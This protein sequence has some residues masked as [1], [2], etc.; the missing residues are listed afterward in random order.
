MSQNR[1][2]VATLVLLALLGVTMWRMSSREAEDR[3]PPKVEVKLPK[4]DSATV[5]ELEL[6]APDK[7]GVRLVK[8]DDKWR[9]AEPLD[10]AADPDTVKTALDKLRELEVTGVAATKAESHEKLEVDPKKAT[11]VIARAGGKTLLDAYVGTYLSGNTM[12]RLEGQTNVATVKGS[13][14]YVFTKQV[15]EW[16]DR[17]IHK[18]DAKDVQQ[19]EFSNK[20]GH[21]AF[22]R[23]GDKWKQVLAKGD[24]KIDPLDDSKL[25]GI[26]STAVNLNATDFADAAITPEQAGLGPSAA[27]V[28]LKLGGD[29]GPQE[30]VYR[31][32]S[33]KDQDYYFQLEGVDTI[34]VMSSWVGGRL[35][36]STDTLVKKP[37]P[38]NNAPPGSPQNPIKV[39]PIGSRMVP[40][41]AGDVHAMGKPIVAIKPNPA[42]PKPAAPAPKK[43]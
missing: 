21:F 38:A 39:D 41:P 32:G 34:F 4:I 26:L 19:V 8:K 14:R 28:R 27:S 7:P 25:T 3:T 15:R 9:L 23:E 29:A 22:V 12:L 35:L 37:E 6:H 2:G 18:G 36:A 33:Q 42:A 1:L 43:K 24:K 13:I 17:T 31:I 30:V 10:A 16:R 11:H 20:N 5:D 40:A